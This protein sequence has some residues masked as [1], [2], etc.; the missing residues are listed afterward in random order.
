MRL[1]VGQLRVQILVEAITDNSC[2]AN[3]QGQEQSQHAADEEERLGGTRAE[4][5]CL[6][7]H[8]DVCFVATYVALGEILF[9]S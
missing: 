2:V 5:D 4:C 9:A 7:A 3:G 6:L 1:V 8:D